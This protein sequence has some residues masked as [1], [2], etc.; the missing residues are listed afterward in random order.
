MG[1]SQRSSMGEE[2]VGWAIHMDALQNT[3]NGERVGMGW[4]MER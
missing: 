1:G 3:Y 2:K 4:L